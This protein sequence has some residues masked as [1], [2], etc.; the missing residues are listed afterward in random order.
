[1]PDL[2]TSWGRSRARKAGIDVPLVKSYIELSGKI[3]GYLTVIDYAG[4]SFWNCEC[5]CG[6][7]KKIHSQSLRL[8]KTTSCG[9]FLKRTKN[10]RK[11]LDNWFWPRITKTEGCW[12]WDAVD[13]LPYG[14]VN[15]NKK[16]QSAHRVS[17]QL[18]NGKI[19]NGLSVLHKC[20]NPACVNPEHLFLGTHQDNMNDMVSK[21]RQNNGGLRGEQSGKSK[22]T[23]EQV[24]AIQS[25]NLSCA[26]LAKIYGISRSGIWY[27]KSSGWNHLRG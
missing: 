11:N 7:K 2:N 20:D 13:K 1:M 18:F 6:T 27:I 24:K 21:G 5:K 25:S 26:K 12:E 8:G 16:R 14:S 22:M 10:T 4:K 9:C 23:N 15:F 17:Y 19:H 3:F